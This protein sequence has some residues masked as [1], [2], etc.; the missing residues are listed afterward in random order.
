MIVA[1]AVLIVDTSWQVYEY[2]G[3][4]YALKSP[5][6]IINL[7]VEFLQ[8]AVQLEDGTG[9]AKGG[10]LSLLCCRVDPR[11]LLLPEFV[12]VPVFAFLERFIGGTVGGTVGY[13]RC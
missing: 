1:C 13:W 12:T 2:G 7:V 11:L 4:A 10:A 9:V 3:F 6:F 8:P 5:E